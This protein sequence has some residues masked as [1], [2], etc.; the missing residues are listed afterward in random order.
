M[1]KHPESMTSL[2]SHVACESGNIWHDL[3]VYGKSKGSLILWDVY[4]KSMG[5]QW[6]FYGKSMKSLWEVYWRSMGSL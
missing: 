2:T 6:G 3:A 4:E 1:S 5:S